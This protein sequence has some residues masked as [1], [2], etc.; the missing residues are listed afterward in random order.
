MLLALVAAYLFLIRGD[1]ADTGTTRQALTA[2]RNALRLGNTGLEESQRESAES[3][4]RI[5][6]LEEQLRRT[7]E[8]PDVQ[9]SEVQTVATDL[10]ARAV[11]LGEEEWV[12]QITGNLPDPRQPRTSLDDRY[13]LLNTMGQR[14]KS[15]PASLKPIIALW[16]A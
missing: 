15:C 3:D 14:L 2:A 10:E 16:T 11:R 7:M 5:R 9:S 1:S 12:Q 4:E 8:D 13:R 6:D